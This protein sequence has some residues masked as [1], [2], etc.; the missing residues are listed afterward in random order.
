MITT[1]IKIKFLSVGLEELGKEWDLVSVR[2][3]YMYLFISFKVP[4][5]VCTSL[6]IEIFMGNFDGVT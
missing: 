2:K 1:E 5:I 4:L 6:E 3:T